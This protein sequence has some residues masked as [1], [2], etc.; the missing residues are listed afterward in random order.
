MAK[1]KP[2]ISFWR[3]TVLS[4]G[5]NS[6]PL[7]LQPRKSSQ[8]PSLVLSDWSDFG[9]SLTSSSVMP[10]GPALFNWHDRILQSSGLNAVSCSVCCNSK[11][12]ESVES[13]RD[14]VQTL[15]VQEEGD[16]SYLYATFM[17]SSCGTAQASSST[18]YL[19]NATMLHVL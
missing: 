1:Y 9:S 6:I 17:P 19:S 11:D 13:P 14:M 18:K 5:F 7:N 4:S 2:R 10:A 12:K 15:S 16:R 8:P 3:F